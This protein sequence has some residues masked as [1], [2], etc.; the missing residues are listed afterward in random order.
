FAVAKLQPFSALR[1]RFYVVEHVFLSCPRPS[2]CNLTEST[3]V[4][5]CIVLLTLKLFTLLACYFL[6]SPRKLFL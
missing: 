1:K 5:I 2:H 6:H 4:K 3:N